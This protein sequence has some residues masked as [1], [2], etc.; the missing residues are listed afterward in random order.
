MRLTVLG[1]SPAST[2]PGGAASGYLVEEGTTRVLLDCGSGSLGNLVEH[3]A[4]E[5]VDA[6]V[7]SHMHADHMLD[8]VPYRYA[9]SFAAD[10]AGG[11]AGRVPR[12]ALFLPP[13]GTEKALSVSRLQDPS[14]SFFAD[15]FDVT[16]Y[17]PGEP[18][19]V[20]AL[21]LSFVAVLHIEHTYAIR[22][23]GGGRTL[24][25]SA[26][27]GVCEGIYEAARGVD[28]FLCECANPA[29]STFRYHLTAAQAGEIAQ[30]AGAGR[31]LLTHRWYRTGL[32]EARVEAGAAFAGPVDLAREGASW[33]I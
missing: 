18:L 31:L 8:L 1:C 25:Y 14:D 23:S 17:D 16:E 22:V 9:L 3:A 26:D 33:G 24:A 11:A 21:R 28:L 2:N 5:A 12:P 27:T 10:Q 32:E 7:I 15:C 29:G 20:G 4:P 13:G 6:V 19:Q 30:V